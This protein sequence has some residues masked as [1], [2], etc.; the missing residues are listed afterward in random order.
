MELLQETTFFLRRLPTTLHKWKHAIPQFGSLWLCFFKNAIL[1]SNTDHFSISLFKIYISKLIKSII[2][3]NKNI[4]CNLYYI[5]ENKTSYVYEILY[6]P[7]ATKFEKLF[8]A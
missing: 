8:L 7:A 4:H 6:V 3:N 1:F 5:N 2:E